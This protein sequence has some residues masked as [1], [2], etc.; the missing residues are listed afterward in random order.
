[1]EDLKSSGIK[2][3]L[4]ASPKKGRATSRGL[5]YSQKL[6]KKLEPN[7]PLF[8]N[9]AEELE[10]RLFSVNQFYYSPVNEDR[11]A[12]QGFYKAEMIQWIKTA[13][14]A[15]Y[16]LDK[17]GIVRCYNG[18]FNKCLILH[19][20]LISAWNGLLEQQNEA[21]LVSFPVIEPVVP[22]AVG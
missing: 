21:K 18:R 7:T 12:N 17:Y 3:L 5:S 22:A 4:T 13:L 20:E 2:I 16:E 10:W 11:R 6:Q 1:M 8:E 19:K 9:K 15:G 14:E